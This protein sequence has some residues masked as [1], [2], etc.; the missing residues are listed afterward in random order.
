[1]DDFEGLLDKLARIP[2]EAR[3]FDT[4][5][6]AARRRYGISP[7]VLGSLSDHGF[8]VSYEDGQA[9]YEESDLVNLSLQ[10]K[11]GSIYRTLTRY[12][13]RALAK[14][15][16]AE[17]VGYQLGYVAE[18]PGD[19]QGTCCFRLLTPDRGYVDLRRTP[20]D[21]GRLYSTEIF[22]PSV[23]PEL[24]RTA[25]ALVESVGDLEL[26]WLPQAL[27][28]D[29]DFMR[30]SCLANCRGVSQILLAEGA[31]RGI[32]VRLAWGL[33]MPPPFAMTHQWAEIDV[34][35]Q[36]IPIDPLVINAMLRWNVLDARRWTP[37]RS[38][39]GVLCRLSPDPVS[40]VTHNRRHVTA[41]FP[42]RHLD[43]LKG[44]QSAA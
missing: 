28:T 43:R 29:V 21:S 13:P 34:D 35:G 7:D 24:P 14:L 23:W 17:R 25:C 2:A 4:T 30:H 11:R 16:D 6:S 33:L 22:L 1:M 41:S 26:F 31:K 5:A 19:G 3:V 39:G 42:V 40:V 37:G 27:R 38:L 8:P 18:C 32:P 44:P 20:Q 10:L 36:P 12:W 15:D 9:R